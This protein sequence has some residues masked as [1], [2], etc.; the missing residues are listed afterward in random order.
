MELSRGE[1]GEIASADWK[2]NSPKI[3]WSE[4]KIFAAWAGCQLWLRSAFAVG[5]EVA[6]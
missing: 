2:S 3:A 1:N 4:G 5:F 6:L